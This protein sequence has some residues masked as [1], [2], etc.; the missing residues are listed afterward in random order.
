MQSVILNMLLNAIDAT[1]QGGHVTVSTGLAAAEGD[2]GRQ[3][4]EIHISDTGCGIPQENLA[5]IFDPFFTTKEV[6]K[7][8]GLGLSVSQGIV[9]KHGGT[10]RV[11]SKPGQ[12]SSFTIWLPERAERGRAR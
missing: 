9:E 3:G 4:V 6:G 1:A 2:P 12:G 7:G 5:R 8:T 10:I 11:S